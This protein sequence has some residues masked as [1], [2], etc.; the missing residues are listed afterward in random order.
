M[1]PS[2]WGT[3][4]VGLEFLVVMKTC[5]TYSLKHGLIHAKPMGCGG[6]GKPLW[7]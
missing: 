5:Y 4:V 7:P 3:G 1:T 2:G 6:Q